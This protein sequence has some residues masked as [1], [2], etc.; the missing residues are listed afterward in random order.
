MKSKTLTLIFLLSLISC[1]E[2]ISID[3]EWL[4]KQDP[5]LYNFVES[6]TTLSGYHN[7]DTD[8]I[9][10]KYSNTYKE[11]FKYIDSIIKVENW[12]IK[13]SNLFERVLSKKELSI[14][15]KYDTLHKEMNFLSDL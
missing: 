6:N 12:T 8:K 10:F 3:N 2:N 4:K 13:K 11:P 14:Y 15:I 1:N 5:E 7:I 9:E